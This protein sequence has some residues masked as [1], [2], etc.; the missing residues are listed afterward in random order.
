MDVTAHVS[1]FLALALALAHASANRFR[2][3][4]SGTFAIAGETATFAE[5][6]LNLDRADARARRRTLRHWHSR[7]V[8]STVR[9][10]QRSS[11][12]ERRAKR[13]CVWRDTWP[14]LAR[15]FAPHKPADQARRDLPRCADCVVDDDDACPWAR[16]RTFAFRCSELLSTVSQPWP[17]R[18]CVPLAGAALLLLLEG[19]PPEIP[20]HRCVISATW[21]WCSLTSQGCGGGTEEYSARCA[22]TKAALGLVGQGLSWVCCDATS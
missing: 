13:S 16:V 5:P 12:E 1:L 21:F 20:V 19:Q 4:C 10:A 14:A 8:F 11:R 3:E 15:R 7:C 22:G 2:A 6:A 18:D 17:L 9:S